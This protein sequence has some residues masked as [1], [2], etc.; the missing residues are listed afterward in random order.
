MET[1]R[2]TLKEMMWY[3]ALKVVYITAYIAIEL[4]IAGALALSVTSIF[5]GETG[6]IQ[7]IISL[8]FVGVFIVPFLFSLIAKSFFYIV[9]GKWSD[10]IK[11]I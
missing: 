4:F 2:E 9:T 3:R 7:V 6:M 11:N 10:V 1:N 8:V 5:T